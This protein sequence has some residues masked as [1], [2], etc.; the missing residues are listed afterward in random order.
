MQTSILLAEEVGARLEECSLLFKKIPEDTIS[1]D[2]E[3]STCSNKVSCVSKVDGL[4]FVFIIGCYVKILILLFNI[5][6]IIYNLLLN[7]IRIL[8]LEKVYCLVDS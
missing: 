7:D 2:C 8:Y 4:F 1:A 3:E 5:N 6:N